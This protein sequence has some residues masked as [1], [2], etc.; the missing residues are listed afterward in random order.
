[1]AISNQRTK[2]QN[3]SPNPDPYQGQTSAMVLSPGA[4]VRGGGRQMTC[5]VAAPS[6]AIPSPSIRQNLFNPLS[7][8]QSAPKPQLFTCRPASD[9]AHLCQLQPVSSP[10]TH[11]NTFTRACSQHMNTG[12]P[13]LMYFNG[14]GGRNNPQTRVVLTNGHAPR[15][16]DFFEG[17]PTGCG[18]INF[19]KTNYLITFAKINCKGNLVNNF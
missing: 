4:G 16:P 7:L 5:P 17:P 6:P 12:V 2:E 15:G 1:M 9:G 10:L 13:R 14:A 19:L 11:S 18:E 3:R 8:L